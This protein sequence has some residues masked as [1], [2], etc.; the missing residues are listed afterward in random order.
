MIDNSVDRKFNIAIYGVKESPKGTQRSARTKSDIHSCVQILKQAND[1]ISV[2][3]IRDCLRLGKYNSSEP[4]PRPLLVKLTCVFDADT[5]LYNRSKI[6][7][8]IQVK[9]DMNHEEKQR[10]SL[11]LKERWN[12]ICSGIDK[13]D[14]KICGTKLY[15]KSQI[16]GEIINSAFVPK[17]D[18]EVLSLS[19]N[20]P[21]PEHDTEML[22]PSNN[23]SAM[24]LEDGSASGSH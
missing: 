23:D 5:V 15:V 7:D 1:D 9:P 4:R 24:E 3:S 13:K 20:D 19:N 12:L 16:H 8:S 2:Q 6:T 18:T 22:S 11:L 10:E 21:V 17:H 14:I